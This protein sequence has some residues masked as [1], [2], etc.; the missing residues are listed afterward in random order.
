MGAA[1][2][3]GTLELGERCLA[4]RK[5]RFSWLDRFSVG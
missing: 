1:L 3:E 2:L 4:E 5:C